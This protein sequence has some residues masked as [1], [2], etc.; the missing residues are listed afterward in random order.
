MVQKT[1]QELIAMHDESSKTHII[2]NIRMAYKGK[3]SGERT[4]IPR[5]PDFPKPGSND[6]EIDRLLREIRLVSGNTARIK[7]DALQQAVDELINDYQITTVMMW[8]TEYLAS[9]GIIDVLLKRNI[10]IVP[11][12]SKLSILADCDLGITEVDFA[13]SETGTL[14]LTSS[15]VK[16]R[17]VSLLP[18]IHLAILNPMN[19]IS[20]L[21][22]L[23]KET[24]NSKY[25]I[26][27]TGPSRTADIELTVSLGVHG[28][29]TLI[30]WVL[31][32]A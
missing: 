12:G 30:V 26:F 3:N 16:P 5:I 8:Q 31:E 11:P 4:D 20:N 19:V 9:S 1:L 10:K 6:E 22:L 17:L 23:F 27:I 15:A 28:P 21:D 13:L 25:S 24:K 7:N 32:P 2:H 14:V 29:Q 18:R